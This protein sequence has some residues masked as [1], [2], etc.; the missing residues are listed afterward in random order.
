MRPY[1]SWPT[2]NVLL[3]VVLLTVGFVLSVALMTTVGLT[4]GLDRI[5]ALLPVGVLLL[6]IILIG[7]FIYQRRSRKPH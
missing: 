7:N 3:N 4:V 5:E 6:I 1:E 2:K